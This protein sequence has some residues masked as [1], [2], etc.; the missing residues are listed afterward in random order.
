MDRQTAILT[1]I[2]SLSSHD[3]PGL[4][5]SLFFKGC[6]LKCIWCHNPETIDSSPELEWDAKS[7]IGCRICKVNCP[8]K[9]IVFSEPLSYIINKNRCTVCGICVETCP[10]KA[11]KRL[12]DSYTVNQLFERIHKDEKFIKRSNGGITFSGGEPALQYTFIAELAQKLKAAGYHLA[13]DTCG[14]AP[15]KAYEIL[16]P[17]MDLILY[18]LKEMNNEKHR[19]LTGSPNRLV[20]A[21]ISLILQLIQQNNLNTEVWIRTPLIPEMTG[22]EE[23]IQAIGTFLSQIGSVQK[24]ELCTFNN[25]CTTKYRKLGQKWELEQTDLLSNDDAANLLDLAK[26]SAPKIASI[27][28]SGLTKTSNTD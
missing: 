17:L 16:V 3:G 18:D 6:S 8:K 15:A 20:H 27:T 28:L 5:T 13:L 19:H 4:R 7:C 23:N 11:L 22:T 12:G 24:W 9:A 2:R 21:N 14:S 26:R 1:E 10:S 25:L